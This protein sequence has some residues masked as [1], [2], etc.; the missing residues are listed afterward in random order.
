MSAANFHFSLLISQ[1]PGPVC[2]NSTFPNFR[3]SFLLIHD[4]LV[5]RQRSADSI[6]G[7]LLARDMEGLKQVFENTSSECFFV[8]DVWCGDTQVW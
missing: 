7:L 5:K 6:V 1:P 4:F 3:A 8:V 2:L